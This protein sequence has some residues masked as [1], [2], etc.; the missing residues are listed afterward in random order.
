MLLLAGVVK[1][2][3]IAIHGGA[4]I[5]PRKQFSDS[6]KA[7]YTKALH[8]CLDVGWQVLSAG[9]SSLDAVQAAIVALEDCPLF[10]AGKGS[11]LNEDGRIECDAA[12][13]AGDGRAG[14]AAGIRTVRN[15]V[16]L[17]RKLL[18]EGRAV[19]LAGEGAERFARD[20]ALPLVEEDYFITAQRRAELDDA[21]SGSKV[22][23]DSI[24]FGTVGAV[25]RDKEGH[26]AA[27][28][29]TGGMSNKLV[30]RI[31]DTPVIGAGTFAQDG[32]CAVSCT[33]VGEVFIRKVVAHEI[34]ARVRLAGQSL[35]DA[36]CEVIYKELP[37]LGGVGGLIAV[38]AD[39]SLST[40]FNARTMYR[41]WRK[42]RG[43]PV[44]RIF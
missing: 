6:L 28:T 11:V 27:A 37:P 38:G 19:F 33:G 14:A 9:G 34:A 42:G 12:M 43:K 41:A 13:M 24:K 4:G 10:N 40:H 23:L 5:F 3:S 31:G 30:G 21:R 20:H 15:P 44:A 39:G 25:A 22:A 2:A 36:V 1:T 17:A 8:D 35:E 32:V 7:R 29:S 18:D 26:L 16:L